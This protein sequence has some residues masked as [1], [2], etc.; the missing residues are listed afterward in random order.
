[1]TKQF[2]LTFKFYFQSN[3]NNKKMTKQLLL[4]QIGK[5][6]LISNERY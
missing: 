4:H 1:M 3:F 5:T 6:T 2:L